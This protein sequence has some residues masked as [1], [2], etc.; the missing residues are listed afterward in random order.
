MLT[1]GGADCTWSG[2]GIVGMAQGS[3]SYAWISGD[4]WS[5]QQV[6]LHTQGGA[7]EG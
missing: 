5:L 1:W 7:E 2:K 4:S 3:W 6:G